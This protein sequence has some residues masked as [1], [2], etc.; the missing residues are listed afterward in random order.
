MVEES[1]S[2]GFTRY[3]IWVKGGRNIR[4]LPETTHSRAEVKRVAGDL[5]ALLALPVKETRDD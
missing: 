3:Y 5:R 1:I 2:D 4:L